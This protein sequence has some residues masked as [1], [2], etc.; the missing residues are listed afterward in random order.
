MDQPGAVTPQTGP[1]TTRMKLVMPRAYLTKSCAQ[2]GAEF[3][4]RNRRTRYCSK[5]CGGLARRHPVLDR[6]M[7]QIVK[8][9]AGCWEWTGRVLPGPRGYGSMKVVDRPR[10]QREQLVHRL[11]WIE[12]NGPIPDGLFV[13]H[14][15]DNPP[16]CNPDHLFLGTKQDNAV[17]ALKKDRLYIPVGEANGN[18]KLT[19]DAVREIRTSTDSPNQAAA[20]YGVSPALVYAVRQRRI[21]R[22]ID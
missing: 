18:A 12:V 7:A 17:D 11:M 10:N 13:L 15:C 3:S 21:W 6:I 14:R 16:C 8:T 1:N 19:A 9:A 22:H 20:R 5:R 2:C 4:T